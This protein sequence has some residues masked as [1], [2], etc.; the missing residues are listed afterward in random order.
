[1]NEPHDMP[2]GAVWPKAAQYAVNAIR[3]VDKTK[4]IYVAGDGWSS[5]Q[6]WEAV[7]GG[8][9]IA[10]PSNNLRYEAHLYFDS[11]NSGTY[12]G[13]YDADRTYPT[14][15]VDRLQP[16]LS[17]LARTHQK[18]FIGEYGIPANDPRYLDAMNRFLKAATAAGVDTTYW[19]AGPWLGDYPLSIQPNGGA[20]PQ[21]AVLRPFFTAGTPC[22]L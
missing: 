17:F 22:P 6:G 12:Q 5:A 9:A 1:M 20:R 10:D 4:R 21:L 13:S 18:G 8:L 3:S 15:G 16:F 19:A 11:N 14:I 7:N 2:S